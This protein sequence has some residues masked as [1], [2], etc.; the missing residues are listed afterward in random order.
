VS[1]TVAIARF[2][3]RQGAD[4]AAGLLRANQIKCAVVDPPPPT[5]W[6]M[7]VRQ[8][9]A[10][11]VARED[12]RRAREAL[13]GFLAARWF[14][15]TADGE[16]DH[17]FETATPERLRRYAEAEEDAG[18]WAAADCARLARLLEQHGWNLV[19]DAFHHGRTLEGRTLDEWA[20]ACGCE[21]SA[22][23]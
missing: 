19:W 20:H 14:L 18:G 7:G 21:Q 9:V 10:V 5:F 2:Q 8:D 17:A 23:Q 1:E 4:D 16:R 6:S 13:D 15:R 11:V 22:N 3:S 12:E